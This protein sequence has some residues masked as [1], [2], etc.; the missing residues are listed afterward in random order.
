V[1]AA[2]P[3]DESERVEK[4]GD[5]VCMLARKCNRFMPSTEAG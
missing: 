1:D 3:L 5:L 2:T 4:V